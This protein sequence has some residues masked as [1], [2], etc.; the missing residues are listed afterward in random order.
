[1]IKGI[2]ISVWQGDVDFEQV[3]NSGINFVILRDGY[4]KDSTN[5]DK[6]FLEYSEQI[7]EVEGLEVK[8]VYH[9]SYALNEEAARQEARNCVSNIIK[10]GLPTSTIAFFD[11]EYDTI[12]YAARK[13]ITLTSKECNLHTRAFCEEVERLG[14]KAGIYYN[15]DY[16]RNMYDKHLLNK[17]VKWL[18]DW[19][20]EPDSPCLFHQ[21]SD[22]GIVPGIVGPVDMNYYLGDVDV[23]SP[24][25]EIDNLIWTIYMGEWGDGE[26]RKLR[27]ESHG[28]DYHKI[29]HRINRMEVI[30]KQCIKGV[31]DNGEDRKKLLE[32][33]GY[34]YEL[35]QYR[36][37]QLMKTEK[38]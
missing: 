18:A 10:A 26:E 23:I 3:K 14:F 34:N 27:L 20:G 22:K 13:G 21:Y 15:M 36:V 4:G 35:V 37:N 2:D 1:M 8:G 12:K 30:A 24:S 5:I 17:Y 31:W 19:T 29:Q 28:H 32:D 16:Y 38:G 11:F 9:F 7:S 33:V 25:E 6:K